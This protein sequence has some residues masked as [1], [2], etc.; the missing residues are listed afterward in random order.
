MLAFLILSFCMSSSTDACTLQNSSSIDSFD[1]ETYQWLVGS[2]KGNGFG[3]ISEEVWAPPIDGTMMGMYRHYKDGKIIFYEFMLLDQ[4]G[5]HLK[6]FHADL[7]G[8][9]EKD[10]FV[11]FETKGQKD[12]QIILKGLQFEKKSDT[13]MQIRLRMRRGEELHTE[14]F[15]MQKQ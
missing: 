11:T 4:D 14:V 6:H 9:E 5:L 15:D 7:K 10:D 1:I 13:T 12:G 8:W 2:W 3:G